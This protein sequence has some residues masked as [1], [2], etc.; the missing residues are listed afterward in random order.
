VS[1][2][3]A[4]ALWADIPRGSAHGRQKQD[5]FSRHRDGDHRFHRQFLVTFL[6]I[7][8]RADFVFLWLKAFFTAWPLAALV[9][10][11]AIPLAR[12]LTQRLAVMLDGKP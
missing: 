10:F 8:F 5:H 12:R 9:A 6:N 3:I 2:L 4:I 7:G 1:G 11:F